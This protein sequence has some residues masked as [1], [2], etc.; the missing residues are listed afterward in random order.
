MD[1]VRGAGSFV[2]IEGNRAEVRRVF[3]KIEYRISR[4][5]IISISSSRFYLESRIELSHLPLKEKKREPQNISLY[6]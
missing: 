3:C 1:M 4:E 2:I 6:N 5:L